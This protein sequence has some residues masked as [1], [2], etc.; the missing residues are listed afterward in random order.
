MWHLCELWC[1]FTCIHKATQLFTKANLP[2][3][4][5]FTISKGSTAL[6]S[7]LDEIPSGCVNRWKLLVN[8]E[9]LNVREAMFSSLLDRAGTKC[10]GILK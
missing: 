3:D 10:N 6:F 1:V 9:R 4:T 7:T 8:R 2:S 5:C